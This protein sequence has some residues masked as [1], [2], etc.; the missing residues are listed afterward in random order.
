MRKTKILNSLLV[1]FNIL[2]ITSLIIALII[3]NNFKNS[4]LVYRT[5]THFTFNI[6]N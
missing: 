4:I 2:I 3:K 5:T 1:V 6:S